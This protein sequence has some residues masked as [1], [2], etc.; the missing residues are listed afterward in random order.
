MIVLNF[1]APPKAGK[2]TICQEVKSRLEEN[3]PN[4]K[5]VHMEFKNM[6]FEIAIRAS[7]MTR[8]MWFS[9]YEREYKEKPCPYLMVNG[10]NV[11]PRDWMIHCSENLM[12]PVF[13]NSV[14]GEAFAAELRKM[15]A[16]IEEGQ[17]LVVVISDGGFIEESIPVIK[18]AG[19]ENY[20]LFRIHRDKEDGA[21]YDFSGDSR[22]YIYAEEFP[23]ELSFHE[24]DVKNV[25]N[26]LDITI[27]NILHKVEQVTGEKLID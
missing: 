23:E 20:F 7:G 26:K 1:N 21:E 3:N 13:G 19:P 27:Q 11:S 5:V 25:N 15:K 6:L 18:E 22:R 10:V 14:F 24:F 4:L 16:S 12:K 8:D 9:H 2:D 17:K